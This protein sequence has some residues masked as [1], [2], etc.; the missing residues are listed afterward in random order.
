MRIMSAVSSAERAAERTA[1]A[2]ATGREP[3]FSPPVERALATLRGRAGAQGPGQFSLDG[4]P[5]SLREI[6][7]EANRIRARHGHKLIAYP[8]E[9]GTRGGGR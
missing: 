7:R 8:G 6:V 1:S 4:R 5:T 9:P 3:P 2:P